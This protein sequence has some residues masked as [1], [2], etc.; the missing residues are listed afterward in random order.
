MKQERT[1]Y[2]I[3]AF[4]GGICAWGVAGNR[5]SAMRELGETFM[6]PSTC[7]EE[8][9]KLARKKGWRVVKIILKE[10]KRK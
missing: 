10:V 8:G 6:L 7:W 2:G 3:L 1:A 5:R 9:Y 4:D